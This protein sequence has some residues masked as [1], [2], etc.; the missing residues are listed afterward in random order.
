MLHSIILI[1]QSTITKKKWFIAS[2][3]FGL[4]FFGIRGVSG[5]RK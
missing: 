2:I 3:S 4:I 5:K 1:V